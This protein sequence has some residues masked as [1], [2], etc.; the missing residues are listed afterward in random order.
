MSCGD[1]NG[2]V[3]SAVKLVNDKT[4]L[5]LCEVRVWGPK[6]PVPDEVEDEEVVGEM[7]DAADNAVST[8]AC[9]AGTVR[10][11]FPESFLILCTDWSNTFY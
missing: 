1:G 9:P 5:T 4:Y 7:S 3:G 8:A 11:F 2:V 10:L 6:E